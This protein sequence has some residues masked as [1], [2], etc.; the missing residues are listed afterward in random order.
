M[1]LPNYVSNWRGT[2]KARARTTGERCSARSRSAFSS[3]FS[4]PADRFAGRPAAIPRRPRRAQT[5]AD[6]ASARFAENGGSPG[7]GAACAPPASP[8]RLRVDAAHQLA[9]VLALPYL[10]AMGRQAAQVP[11]GHK[12]GVRQ[13]QGL[14]FLVRKG[15]QLDAQ[16]L[17]KPPS[18]LRALLL[19]RC[20]SVSPVSSSVSSISLLVILR[21]LSLRSVESRLKSPSKTC[22]RN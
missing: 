2:R 10:R 16:L 14:D 4:K 13:A 21:M 9:D 8:V 19:R 17:Q 11:Q 6:R 15:R 12:K 18:R 22:W 7:R 20:S 1:S 5:A 3:S